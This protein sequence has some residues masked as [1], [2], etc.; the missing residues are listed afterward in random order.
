MY[1]DL[2]QVSLKYRTRK[3]KLSC[4]YIRISSGIDNEMKSKKQKQRQITYLSNGYDM[5]Q[6]KKFGVMV[7]NYFGA[8]VL[9]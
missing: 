8:W 2:G 3:R 5:K 4:A 9:E 7:N 6:A 1:D